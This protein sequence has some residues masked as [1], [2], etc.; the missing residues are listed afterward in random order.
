MESAATTTV[1]LAMESDPTAAA[2]PQQPKTPRTPKPK[3]TFMLHDP[4][5][6]TCKG[7]FVASDFRY[8]ALKAASKK[9]T[10]IHLRKT[11]SKEI[12]VFSGSIVLLDEPKEIRRGDRVITYLNKPTVKFSRK[13]VFDGTPPADEEEPPTV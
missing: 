12:R 2:A 1:P 3:S 9:V 8:A 10:D 6:M 5:D 13:Y 4:V 11:N 7:K